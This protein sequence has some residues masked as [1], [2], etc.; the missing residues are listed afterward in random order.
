MGATVGM[1]IS[2]AIFWLFSYK[3]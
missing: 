2:I 1:L 3:R